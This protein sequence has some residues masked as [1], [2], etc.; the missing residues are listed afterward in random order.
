M[1][2]TPF[3]SRTFYQGSLSSIP[4]SSLGLSMELALCGDQSQ[5]QSALFKSRAEVLLFHLVPSSRD[6]EHHH[7]MVSAPRACTSPTSPYLFV[8]MSYSSESPC[9]GSPITCARKLSSMHFRSLLYCFGVF[10]LFFFLLFS[11]FL[12]F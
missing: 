12:F 8:S 4:L 11:F 3:L 7:F 1:P 10:P 2:W 5:G 9:V 6:P